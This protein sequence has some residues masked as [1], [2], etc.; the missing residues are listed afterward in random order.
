MTMRTRMHA[1][2]GFAICEAA[3]GRIIGF[4]CFAL[5]VFLGM[6][7][8]ADW[9]QFRGANGTAVSTETDLPTRWSATDN[10]RWKADLPGR[11]L[12]C[13]IVAGGRAYVTAC[14]GPAQERLH[15]LCVDC[16]TGH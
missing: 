5:L 10:V 4:T 3:S 11:G 15:V 16:A 13:P 2:C 12:S 1:A 9:P 8:A 6:A 7:R 14:T